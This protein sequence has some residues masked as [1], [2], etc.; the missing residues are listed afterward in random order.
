MYQWSKLEPSSPPSAYTTPGRLS[1]SAWPPK[2]P[3][4]PAY[5]ERDLKE[6]ISELYDQRVQKEHEKSSV[7]HLKPS[8][9][10]GEYEEKVARL[11]LQLEKYQTLTEIEELT[12]RAKYVSCP[13][14]PHSPCAATQTEPPRPTLSSS[15]QYDIASCTFLLTRSRFVQT[16]SIRSLSRSIQTDIGS[17]LARNSVRVQTEDAGPDVIRGLP[18]VNSDV[19]EILPSLVTDRKPYFYRPSGSV[20][21]F[22]LSSSTL[23]SEEPEIRTEEH[24][25]LRG[26]QCERCH[27]PETV[28]VCTQTDLESNYELQNLS[29]EENFSLTCQIP[30]PEPMSTIPPP[31]PMPGMSNIPASP[32]VPATSSIPPPPPMPGTSSIPPPPPMPGSGILPPPP[33]P[34]SGIP[35]PPPMPGSGIPPPPPM[36]G[37]GIPPPPPMPGSGIPPPPP[38]PG[39]GIPPPPPM[40][41]SGIPP[42]PPMP[43]SGIPPPPPMPGSGIP[44]PPPPPGF[45]ATPPPPPPPGFPGSPMYNFPSAQVY[46]V[47]KPAIVPKTPMKPLYWTRIQMNTPVASKQESECLW[48][49]LEETPL[50][51]WDEFEELFSKPVTK[52]KTSDEKPKTAQSK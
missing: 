15:S 12:R 51:S 27:K 45:S 46:I 21:S 7:F 10:I 1:P 43:G 4:S 33:M 22:S 47:R 18:R 25:P 20:S 38:M 48:D 26:T 52:K 17:P 19:S 28:A 24:Y 23:L 39:S 3:I 37:S 13:T 16:E 2:T 34:G 11:E 44:P 31:P 49:N 35:P 30:P 5:S 42:P 14:S 41:G 36:P 32:P 8:H 50:E 29:K 9:R 40:L 6:V